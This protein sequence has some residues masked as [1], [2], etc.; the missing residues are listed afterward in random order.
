MRRI[1]SLM[2][3]VLVMVGCASKT[4]M[5]ENLVQA[6]AMTD[7][8]LAHAT[9]QSVMVQDAKQAVISADKAKKTI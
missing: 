2:A 3:V 8:N 7:G 5:P 6:Q 1:V 4:P 9:E